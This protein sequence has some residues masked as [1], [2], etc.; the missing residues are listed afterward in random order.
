MNVNSSSNRVGDAKPASQ[1]QKV[2]R[3]PIEKS[4]AT[5]APKQLPVAD[6]VE[7]SGVAKMLESLKAGNDVRV[8]K[9]AQVKAE[10][11]KG[12]YE[13]D[14]KLDVAADRLLDDLLK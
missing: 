6:R 12:T 8:D 13:T 2:V 10:I 1:V 3:K 5:D 14:K 7:I 4:V 9:V 11:A